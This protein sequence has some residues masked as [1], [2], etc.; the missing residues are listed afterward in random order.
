M[1][2]SP[3]LPMIHHAAKSARSLGR[4]MAY[5]R[6]ADWLLL[7]G[8]GNYLVDRD[9]PWAQSL[10]TSLLKMGGS[11]LPGWALPAMAKCIQV[12]QKMH[13]GVLRAHATGEAVVWLTWPVPA[14]VVAAFP[15]TVYIPESVYS[16]ANASHGD[17]STRMCEVADRHGIPP[18][19]CSINRCMLGAFLAD[20][21]PTPTLCI[22]ANHPCDG[23][24]A[25]NT[26]LRELAPCDHFSMGAAYD[27]SPESIA[28]WARSVWE[29][30]AFLEEKLGQPLDW[31]RLAEHAKII[32]RVNRALNR[33]TELHR[34]SPA[35]GLIN[36]LAVFWRLVVSVGWEPALAEGAELLEKS[37][38][39]WVE[40]ARRR[41]APRERLRVVLGDQAI[42]WTDFG[43]WLR[44][45]YG[46][47]VVCDYIGHFH[48]PTIDLSSR[49]RMLEGLTLDRLHAS[50]IRQAHGTM[51]YTLD[52][53]S[54]FLCEYDADCVIFH[55]NVGCKHNLALRRE[56]EALCRS[57]K[58]P[59]LFLDADIVDRRVIGEK[60]LRDKI[61]TFL[62][63]EGLP[64]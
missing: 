54:T 10:R 4:L 28:L 56:I 34:N 26:I 45:E 39:A 2:A 41:Q 60:P 7:R 3:A 12:T 32:N 30:I 22:T 14:A 55:G 23:N 61:R 15:V 51:E 58:V 11:A 9:P 21:L 27:R 59:A 43:P 57:V 8:L 46:A 36:A 25:G 63:A 5:P 48:H 17:G 29:L 24:H 6:L 16:V 42:T 62:A 44:R 64:R 13:E 53:L 20:E 38:V 40:D 47:T 52:E 33:I 31:D 50:M 37:A 1:T 18:E 19:M 49:E 35:P